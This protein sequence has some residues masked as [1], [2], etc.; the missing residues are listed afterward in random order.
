MLNRP[1]QPN[2][3]RWL[4][5]LVTRYSADVK[6]FTL[7]TDVMTECAILGSYEIGYFA[8]VALQGGQTRRYYLPRARRYDRGRLL[9]AFA[10]HGWQEVKVL[11]YGPGGAGGV[12]VVAKGVVGSAGLVALACGP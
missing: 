7:G 4:G 1:L 2:I 11:P 5:G 9:A 10:R 6:S 3:E 8:D 12:G